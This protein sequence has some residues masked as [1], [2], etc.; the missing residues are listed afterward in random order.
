[1]KQI[2]DE[3]LEQISQISGDIYARSNPIFGAGIG[4]PLRN[5]RGASI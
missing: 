2:W 5:T 3:I 4:Y 1:M